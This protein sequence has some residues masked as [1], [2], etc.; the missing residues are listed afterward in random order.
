ME[1]PTKNEVFC[2]RQDVARLLCIITESF[3][4]QFEYFQFS[5]DGA[6]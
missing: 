3:L 6:Y 4:I 1:A 5:G 2:A